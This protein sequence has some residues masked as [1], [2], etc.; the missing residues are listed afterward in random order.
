MKT[1]VIVTGISDI[2]KRLKTLP[3]R[4]QKKVVS[5]SMRAGLA[6]VKSE[7]QSQVPVKSGLTRSQVKIRAV[8]R[9]RRDIIEL[10]VRIGGGESG[11]GLIKT[12]KSGKRTFYP[13]VVEYKHDPF[14]RRAFEASGDAARGVTIQLLRDGVEREA[15]RD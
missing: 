5:Q 11:E 14:M 4:I 8:K 9:K 7:V 6:G 2:D 12:T 13:A 3:L 10:E 1:T 15:E